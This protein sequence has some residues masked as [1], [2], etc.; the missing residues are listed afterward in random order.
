MSNFKGTKGPWKVR[1]SDSNTAWNVT[2]TCAGLKYKIARC[3]YI[4][5]NNV[6]DGVEQANKKESDESKANALLISKAPEMLEMLERISERL[7]VYS[8]SDKDDKLVVEA[9]ELIK[10]ATEI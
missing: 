10:S 8:M 2:G 7:D 1:H 9:I 5:F 6:F 4:T 3:P